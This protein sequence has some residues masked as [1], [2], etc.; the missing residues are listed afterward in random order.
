MMVRGK[1]FA[2]LREGGDTGAARALDRILARAGP[3]ARAA[4]V[5]DEAEGT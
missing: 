4:G 3:E 5:R 2:R 1:M